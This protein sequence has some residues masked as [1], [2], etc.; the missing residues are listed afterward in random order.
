MAKCW[1][2]AAP[3][4]ARLTFHHTFDAAGRE[5]ARAMAEGRGA[6]GGA[7]TR[8][9]RGLPV[10]SLSIPAPRARVGVRVALNFP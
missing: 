1:T 9:L 5:V 3:E 7:F 2:D 4:R 10:G 6:P 8:C